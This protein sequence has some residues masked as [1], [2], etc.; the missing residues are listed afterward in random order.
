MVTRTGTK[1]FPAAAG[2]FAV[3]LPRQG[4]VFF[5]HFVFSI[6]FL[7]QFVFHFNFKQVSVHI[8]YATTYTVHVDA[9]IIFD[10]LRAYIYNLLYTTI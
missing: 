8:F 3:S 1:A 7:F 6:S 5:F 10:L 9:Y 2:F 4:F